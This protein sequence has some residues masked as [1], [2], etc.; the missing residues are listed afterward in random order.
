MSSPHDIRE[1]EL[2]SHLKTPPWSGAVRDHALTQALAAF[3]EA[4]RSQTDASQRALPRAWMILSAGAACVLLAAA[5][6]LQPRGTTPDDSAAMFSEMEQLFPSQLD[7]VI[8]DGADVTVK[9]AAEPMMTPED[10]RVCLTLSKAHGSLRVL[11]YSGRRVCVPVD[12]SVLCLT[13]LLQGDGT[14]FVLTD[15]QIIQD[16]A[17]ILPSGHRLKMKRM[18]EV[19]S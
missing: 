14:V 8:V 18:A 1:R 3:C 9:T 15:T 4:R 19:R 13:P 16:G 17:S 7:S 5:W 11:T 6:W 12:G 2:L 10:Q